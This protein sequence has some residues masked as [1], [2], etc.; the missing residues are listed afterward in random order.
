MCGYPYPQGLFAVQ[1]RKF[2]RSILLRTSMARRR[3]RHAPN[4]RRLAVARRSGRCPLEDG[5]DGVFP[6]RHGLLDW[7][8]E[9]QPQVPRPDPEHG[10]G[11]HP[12]VISIPDVPSLRH[13]EEHVA[14]R[15]HDHLLERHVR[16]RHV[17]EEMQARHYVEGLRLDRDILPWPRLDGHLVRL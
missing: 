9:A 7:T 3:I 10:L 14:P 15:G 16:F 5:V 13:H 1:Y 6:R 8:V 4:I 12:P 11:E 2:S 17:L